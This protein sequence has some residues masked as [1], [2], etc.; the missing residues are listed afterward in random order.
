MAS[1][2]KRAVI[3]TLVYWLDSFSKRVM[4]NM[5]LQ[6]PLQWS[7]K[8]HCLQIVVVLQIFCGSGVLS[9][10]VWLFERNSRLFFLST[11]QEHERPTQGVDHLPKLIITSQFALFIVAFAVSWKVFLDYVTPIVQALGLESLQ[12]I[13]HIE[14]C[15]SV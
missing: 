3:K 5:Y 6:T 2:Q 7:I 14:M 1:D 11:L 10:M 4:Q 8:D 12:Q 15:E 9:Y 13:K